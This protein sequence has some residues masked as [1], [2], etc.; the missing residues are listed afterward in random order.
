MRKIVLTIVALLFVEFCVSA[1]VS[2]T[3]R[4][5]VYDALNGT[6]DPLAGAF[7]DQVGIGNYEVADFYG[8][9]VI[10]LISP[11]GDTRLRAG[12]LGYKI[13]VEPWMGR[14]VIDFPLE[15]EDIA[16]SVNSEDT[17]PPSENSVSG[18]GSV[19]NQGKNE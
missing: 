10:R 16:T 3:D 8:D 13:R 7:V 9:Y 4:G 18:M 17:V 12:V 6:S 15:M 14:S 2:N 19:N 1:Q 11:N 5:K